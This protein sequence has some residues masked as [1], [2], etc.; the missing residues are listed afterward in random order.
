[1]THQ[2]LA[3]FMVE[4]SRSGI[5]IE[6]VLATTPL[7]LPVLSVCSPSVSFTP[8]SLIVNLRQVAPVVNPAGLYFVNG[9]KCLLC[10]QKKTPICLIRDFY[11]N[12]NNHQKFIFYQF[13]K[14]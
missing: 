14:N 4:S 10:N 2:P 13:D 5:A 6:M 7:A 11:I 12:M 9:V 3:I 1:M 8:P